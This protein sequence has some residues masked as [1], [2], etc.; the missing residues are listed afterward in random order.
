MDTFNLSQSGSHYR[1]VNLQSLRGWPQP[2]DHKSLAVEKDES[3]FSHLL[4]W[5]IVIIEQGWERPCILIDL[6][7][8][9]MFWLVIGIWNLRSRGKQKLLSDECFMLTP[10]RRTSGIKGTCLRPI[11]FR[12]RHFPMTSQTECPPQWSEEVFLPVLGQHEG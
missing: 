7:A 2:H 5:W 3:R 11:L 10:T 6:C 12:G 8:S 1:G 4:E 9:V